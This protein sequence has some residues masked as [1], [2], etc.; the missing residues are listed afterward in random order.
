MI[1]IRKVFSKGKKPTRKLDSSNDDIDWISHA[2]KAAKLTSSAAKLIPVAGPFIEG[3]ADVFYMALEP[4]KQMKVNKED[5]KELTQDI[6]T[7]LET[8]NRAIS[9]GFPQT[10]PPVEFTTMCS[11]FKKL[12]DRLLEEY[13]QFDAKSGSRAIRSYLRSGDIKEMISKYQKEVTVLLKNLMVFC[14]ISTNIQVQLLRSDVILSGASQTAQ[15]V[16]DD[17]P[18]FEEFIELKQGHIQLQKEIKGHSDTY[19]YRDSHYYRVPPSFKEHHAVTWVNG[20]AHLTTLRE[21]KGDAAGELLRADLRILARLKHRHITQVLGF[22]KSHIFP[23]I[24]FYEDLRPIGLE[25]YSSIDMSWDTVEDIF[26]KHRMRH[27]IRA[28]IDHIKSKIPSVFKTERANEGYRLIEYYTTDTVR[29]GIYLDSDNRPKLSILPSE[30]LNNYQRSK[31]LHLT[32]DQDNILDES[33]FQALHIQ[34]KGYAVQRSQFETASLLRHFHNIIPISHNVLHLDPSVDGYHLGGMYAHYA[35]AYQIGQGCLCL[36]NLN[37]TY[38]R[39]L[40]ANF[41]LESRDFYSDNW[42]LPSTE[43]N[44]LKHSTTCKGMRLSFTQFQWQKSDSFRLGHCSYLNNERRIQLYESFMT[45]L[46]HFNAKL[47]NERPY[48]QCNLT[49]LELVNGIDWSFEVWLG[50]HTKAAA[51]TWPVDEIFLFVDNPVISEN[52][53]V[54][55]PNIYWSRCPQGSTRLTTLEL[56]IFGVEVPQLS[57]HFW[58]AIFDFKIHKI[59]PLQEFYES[60][61][62]DSFSDDVARAAGALLPRHLNSRNSKQKRRHSFTVRRDIIHD[63]DEFRDGWRKSYRYS[64][65]KNVRILQES[66][67]HLGIRVPRHW[68][69][70]AAAEVLPEYLRWYD[71]R[72][73]G[74]EFEYGEVNMDPKYDE[75][76]SR[77]QD[78]MHDY[79]YGGKSLEDIINTFWY[80]PDYGYGL[81]SDFI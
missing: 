75:L 18:E 1:I 45:Q 81:D 61:G 58:G 64:P 35:Q 28:G 8:L 65:P 27:G 22:C 10:E 38:R 55:R 49:S 33:T 43:E 7:L 32:Y 36:N 30:M 37:S 20:N 19:Y 41:S 57:C 52:G 72:T 39:E 21:Y 47:K 44:N 59:K 76:P 9:I 73:T 54:K 48:F 17:I 42:K 79:Q 16:N 29:L 74:H 70:L 63:C 23:S 15:R 24:I 11:N 4:L 68:R 3:G 46:C 71:L 67:S 26:T 14:A 6:T 78:F 2:M 62:L 31:F 34:F 5:F 51:M 69:L 80:G 40:V 25:E 53:Y 60:C 12:M 77:C 50:N 56:H 66:S 13:T